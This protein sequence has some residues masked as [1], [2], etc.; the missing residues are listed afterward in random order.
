[1]QVHSSKDKYLINVHVEPITMLFGHMIKVTH[2]VH[3]VISLGNP[4]QIP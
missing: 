2:T 1:M 3:G 4:G